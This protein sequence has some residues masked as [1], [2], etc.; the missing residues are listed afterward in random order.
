[1]DKTSRGLHSG[2]H[3]FF[4][5]LNKAQ[6]P[7]PIILW[8]WQVPSSAPAASLPVHPV[9]SVFSKG[10]Q[11]DAVV[12]VVGGGGRVGGVMMNGVVL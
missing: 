5:F 12:V 3:F 10:L 6:R 2:L 1:M 11:E 7:F 8:V 9:G 4:F